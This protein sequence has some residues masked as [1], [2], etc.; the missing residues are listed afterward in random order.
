MWVYYG[1]IISGVQGPGKGYG[2]RIYLP[3]IHLNRYYAA[4]TRGLF[5]VGFFW[6][7]RGASLS[8]RFSPA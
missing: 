2:G 6:G 3:G 8:P 4:E 5:E 1:E 7:A